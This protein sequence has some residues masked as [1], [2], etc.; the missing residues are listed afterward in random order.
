MTD[1][2]KSQEAAFRKSVR[3]A[4]KTSKQL[5]RGQ[6]DVA[7]YIANLWL[8]HRNGP[9]GVI[10][11]GR[12]RIAKK[13]EVSPRTVSTVLKMMREGGVL[14]PVSHDGGGSGPTR[15]TMRLRKIFG[16]CGQKMPE[17]MQGELTEIFD[18]T[19][20]KNCKPKRAKLQGCP[21]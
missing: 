15:Y 3:D 5:T 9:E 19:P 18:R 14:V 16:F 8:H 6:K 4:I 13:T 1:F 2:Q 20:C 10:R 12:A 21:F 7:L 17:F 11:P